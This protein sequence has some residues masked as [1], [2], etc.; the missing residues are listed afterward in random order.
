MFW[1]LYRSATWALSVAISSLVLDNMSGTVRRRI[2]GRERIYVL[3]VEE[4][5]IARPG[6]PSA[7]KVAYNVASCRSV[8]QKPFFKGVTCFVN[9]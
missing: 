7:R 1:V 2:Q 6:D 5:G 4:D 8:H 9:V 3:A